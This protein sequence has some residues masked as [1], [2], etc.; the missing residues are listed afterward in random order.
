MPSSPGKAVQQGTT[1]GYARASCRVKSLSAA[2][3][4]VLCA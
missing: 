3:I 2:A 1:S 4:P